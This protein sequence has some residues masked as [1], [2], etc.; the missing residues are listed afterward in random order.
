MAWCRTSEALV[1]AGSLGAVGLDWIGLAARGF[2]ADPPTVSG[3]FTH[4]ANHQ[5]L[6][7]WRRRRADI[8]AT[9]P[10]SADTSHRTFLT[11]PHA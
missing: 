8:S 5:L 11:T 3:A 6:Q 2:A 1:G 4:I 10:L 9:A 7:S